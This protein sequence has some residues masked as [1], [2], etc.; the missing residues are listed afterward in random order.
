M[1]ERDLFR[2][3]GDVDADL[4][5]DANKVPKSKLKRYLPTVVA[6]CLC[7]AALFLLFPAGRDKSSTEEAGNAAMDQRSISAY[8]NMATDEHSNDFSFQLSWEEK[9]YDSAEGVY[10]P[11]DGETIHAEL[12][13]EELSQ[14]LDLISSLDGASGKYTITWTIMGESHTA[15]LSPDDPQYQDLTALIEAAVNRAQ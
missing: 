14:V 9:S 7:I 12:T 5:E 2:A 10:T 13:Q 15:F 6:A 11:A 8:S 1:N 4:I 3:I